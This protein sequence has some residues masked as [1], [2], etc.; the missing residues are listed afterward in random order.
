MPKAGVRIANLQ[1]DD[2][3]AT[4]ATVRMFVVTTDGPGSMTG[5]LVTASG[6]KVKFC[7]QAATS[8]A[9]C[10]NYGSGVTLTGTTSNKGQT[11]FTITAIGASKGVA[12]TA[13]IDIAFF[14]N[15]PKLEFTGLR[16]DPVRGPTGLDA[17]V[18]VPG[19][20]SIELQAALLDTT[21]SAP[22]TNAPWRVRMVSL[23]GA[24]FPPQDLTDTGATVQVSG[25]VAG[26]GHAQVTL[27]AQQGTSP[28]LVASG[29]LTWP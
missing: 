9:F 3:A 22:A 25:D 19:Q 15:A 16:I 29:S 8:K 23:D 2:P 14:A 28:S 12:P 17:R 20:G 21:T 11:R 1:L 26:A 5:K 24:A 4:D 7:L 10:G 18:T 27:T 6:G 13:T